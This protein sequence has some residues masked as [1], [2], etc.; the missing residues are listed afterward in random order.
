[1]TATGGAGPGPD[2][3]P[4]KL[5]ATL[6]A[7][8]GG[9]ERL[10]HRLAFAALPL[11]K[12]LAELEDRIYARRAA[13]VRVSRPVFIAS[14]PRAGTT[15]LLE[16]IAALPGFATHTYRNMP[17]LLIPLLWNA[18]SRPFHAA[19]GK[20]ERAQSDGVHIDFDSPEAFEEVLWRAFHP[21]QYGA[22]RILPWGAD[23]GFDCAEFDA[24]MEG[25]IRKLASLR[26]GAG[27]A[28]YLSKNN[29]NL[30]RLAKLARLFPDGTL[31][32]PFRNPVDHAASL[33]RQHLLFEQLHAGE[34]FTR[35]YM[36]DLGHYDFGANLRPIDFDHWLDEK[37]LEPPSSANFWLRYWRAAFAH[38]L[39]NLN[40]QTALLSY[41]G[42]C[43]A[44]AAGLQRIAQRLGVEDSAGLMATAATR[45]RLPTRYDA[46]PL[47][48]NQ[49]LLESAQALH[50]ELLSAAI[51]A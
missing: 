31:L 45:F 3:R 6:E 15:L 9:L 10:L 12:S 2:A 51:V 42:L 29:G 28:R 38:V 47:N 33:W 41:D 50:Q 40:D 37:G 32:I 25:H 23:A 19:G 34:P 46:G 22:D 48:L 36:A 26:V 43:A 30:S 27:P 39:A 1:M 16:T 17:F 24:F 18:L 21:A 4:A 7:R 13:G 5:P 14:L 35:R 11:Q 8:Y 44:S 20:V 49:E